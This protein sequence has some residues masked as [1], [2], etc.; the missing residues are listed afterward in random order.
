MKY[1]EIFRTY[2]T[3]EGQLFHLLNKR[4]NFPD[5]KNLEIYDSL[6]IT[7]NTPWTIL[8]YNLYKSIEYWWI[9]TSINPSSIFY[10]KEGEIIYYIK[11]EYLKLVTDL[12]KKD[13]I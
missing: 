11:P 5:N 2:K 7:A 6:E 12:I 4:I 3:K 13:A 1:T 9:L 8:S 10:A